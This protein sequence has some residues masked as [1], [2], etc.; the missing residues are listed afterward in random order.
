MPEPININYITNNPI[1]KLKIF[2]LM[3]TLVVLLLSALFTTS[4]ALLKEHPLSETLV[5]DAG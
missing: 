1:I 4:F 5:N 2:F 3:K